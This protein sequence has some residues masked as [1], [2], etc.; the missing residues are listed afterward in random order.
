MRLTE[1]DPEWVFDFNPQTHGMKRAEDAHGTAHAPQDGS[2]LPP[3]MLSVASAQG[4]MFLCP[5]CFKKNG[6]PIGTETILC[7]FKD[8]GV[9]DSAFPGPGRWTA[10]GTGFEDLTLAPSVNVDHE[11]WHGW[12]TNGETR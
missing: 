3:H 1:L 12:I 7:W 2:E 9:P 8:R 10:S 4:V 11:H 5:A 6:G